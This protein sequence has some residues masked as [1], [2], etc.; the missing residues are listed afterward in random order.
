MRFDVGWLASRFIADHIGIL[1]G[2][3][4]VGY[5][6]SLSYCV[7]FG[8]HLPRNGEG[9]R[10]LKRVCFYMPSMGSFGWLVLDIGA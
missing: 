3:E 6:C 4:R 7:T 2:G 1:N 9:I 8:A 10:P 5:V